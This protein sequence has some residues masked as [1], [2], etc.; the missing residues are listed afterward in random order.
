LL[1]AGDGTSFFYRPANSYGDGNFDSLQELLSSPVT[2]P[3]LGDGGAHCTLISDASNPTYMLT[4]W[5]RDRWRGDR[6]PLELLVKWHAHDTASLFGLDDRGVI[7]AGKKADLNVID[8]DA[9]QVRRPE[10]AYDFPAGGKR[11]VQRADGY[12]ATVVSGEVTYLDGVPTG[13]LPGRTV[14]S[15]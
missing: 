7:A 4:H 5:G 1:V 10:M 6:L 13:A 8:F 11:L 14:R 12:R 2:V 15:R 9:L 3:G